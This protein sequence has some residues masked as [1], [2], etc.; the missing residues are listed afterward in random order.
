MHKINCVIKVKKG[1][2]NGLK[3]YIY[4]FEKNLHIIRAISL[5]IKKAI[6][7][8]NFDR[9]S[10]LIPIKIGSLKI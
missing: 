7:G 8:S 4:S 5:S 3:F 2:E 6:N 9:H 1:E 10:N